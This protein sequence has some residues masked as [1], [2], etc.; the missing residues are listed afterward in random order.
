MKINN[1]SSIPTFPSCPII[2]YAAVIITSNKYACKYNKIYTRS[3]D[4]FAVIIR[5]RANDETNIYKIN[6]LYKT[7][8][9]CKKPWKKKK[10][11]R[12]RV[13]LRR[14]RRHCLYTRV[15]P[16]TPRPTAHPN[17][18]EHNGLMKARAHNAG[19]SSSSCTRARRTWS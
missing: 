1:V 2:Q 7:M 15:Y 3:E 9:V 14:R 8:R 10:N 11:H 13:G 18:F 12:S 6:A 16:L 17:P 19:P 4:D 5:M